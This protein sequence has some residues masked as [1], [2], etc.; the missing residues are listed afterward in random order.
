M[1]YFYRKNEPIPPNLF[2]PRWL[3]DG[4]A[5]LHKPWH[6][7][8]DNFDYTRGDNIHIEAADN[9]GDRS[10]GAGKQLIIDTTMAMVEKHQN[11][12]PG[13][14]EAFA[15]A[16]KKMS[17]SL[18]TNQDQKL[19]RLKAIPR[20]LPD[21][22]VQPKVTFIPGR[23]R[24]LTGR[25]AAELQEK[26]EARRRRRAQIIAEKQAE[27]DARQE[28]AATIRSQL[29]DTVAAEYV[30]SQQDIIDISFKLCTS[31]LIPEISLLRAATSA[32]E[33]G[34]SRHPLEV[35]MVEL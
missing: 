19:H 4:P 1:L 33:V 30:A 21:A 10:L 9:T 5:V 3:I 31:S 27:N 25:E 22:I 13:E 32:S 8:L 24:A 26:E 28:E 14:K 7:R 18:A 6:I 29:H 12:P 15:L 35:V 20:R 17:D 34:G 23:K 11:L 16:F 2:H